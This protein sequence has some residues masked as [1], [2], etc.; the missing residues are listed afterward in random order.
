M[1][2]VYERQTV[3]ATDQLWLID[4]LHNNAAY[5]TDKKSLPAEVEFLLCLLAWFEHQ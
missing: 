5:S 2:S 4:K 3:G 1:V